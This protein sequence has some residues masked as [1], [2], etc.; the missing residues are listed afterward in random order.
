[1]D[2]VQEADDKSGFSTMNAFMFAARVLLLTINLSLIALAT[3]LMLLYW[4]TIGS[5]L[6]CFEPRKGPSLER[7]F[8]RN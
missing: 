2:R 4:M 1:M 5:V 8:V 6:S 3:P 7:A